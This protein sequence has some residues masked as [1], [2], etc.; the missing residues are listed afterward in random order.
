MAQVGEVFMRLILQTKEAEDEMERATENVKRGLTDMDNKAKESGSI[1]RRV[2]RAATLP[3]RSMLSATNQV[4]KGFRRM[5]RTLKNEGENML[6][7]GQE[8]SIG[9]AGPFLLIGAAAVYAFSKTAEGT[10]TLE[11]LKAAFEDA[12]SVMAPMGRWLVMF[13]FELLPRLKSILQQINDW[14]MSLTE[15]QRKWVMYIALALSAFGPLITVLGAYAYLIGFIGSLLSSLV[16]RFGMIITVV[17]ALAAVFIYAYNNIEW[18]RNMVDQ[19]VQYLQNLW[20]QHG[21]TVIAAIQTAYEFV[22]NIVMNVLNGVMAFIGWVL[23]TIKQWWDKHGQDVIASATK[24]ADWIWNGVIKPVYEEISSFIKSILDKIVAWWN[25]HGD[26]VQTAVQN[27]MT[28]IWFAFDTIQT[29]IRTTFEFLK[30]FLKAAWDGIKTIFSGALDVILGLLGV[31]VNLFAG[32]WKGLWESVKQIFTGV[33]EIIKG[34]LQ[35]VFGSILALFASFAKSVINKVK[36]I[37]NSITNYFKS[38]GK[39][40]LAWGRNLL[41]S[42]ING[43][44]SR[45]ARL[46]SAVSNAVSIVK[47]FLGFSSPT[48]KGP[49]RE[50]DEWPVNLVNTFAEGMTATLPN[51]ERALIKTAQTLSILAQPVA[52]TEGPMP[53]P[54]FNGPLVNIENAVVRNDDDIR[55]LSEQVAEELRRMWDDIM[56]T[57]GL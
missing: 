31:F 41:D 50:A 56:E 47:N 34:L 52:I 24:Q 30:P 3:L 44:T 28:I 8:L 38:L 54:T 5:S 1:M 32:D 46:R 22:K 45:F 9:L 51:L 53:A 35:G 11:K 7:T 25:E 29:I 16:T 26:S 39:D 55:K 10:K 33:W 23:D 21:N 57:R 42:F 2:F 27:I 48:K 20:Q 36:E 14:F 6:E 12:L 4:T 40:A 19:A 18:F 13:A 17:L 43:I 15:N 49:G 37:K